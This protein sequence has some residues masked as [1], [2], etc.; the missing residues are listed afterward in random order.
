M[1]GDYSMAETKNLVVP[2]KSNSVSPL[3]QDPAHDV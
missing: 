2:K 1:F 3:R